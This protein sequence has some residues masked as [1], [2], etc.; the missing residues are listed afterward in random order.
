[1]ET[2]GPSFSWRAANGGEIVL[3]LVGQT[4]A[5]LPRLTRRYDP[6]L[7][8]RVGEA[9]NPGPGASRRNLRARAMQAA[10]AGGGQVDFVNALVQA[11]LPAL[12]AALNRGGQEQGAAEAGNKKEKDKKSDTKVVPNGTVKAAVTRIQTAEHAAAFC[13]AK[14]VAPRTKTAAPAAADASVP[15]ERDGQWQKVAG[16]IADGDWKLQACDWTA[17]VCDVDSL[18]DAV[19]ALPTTQTPLAR[20]VLLEDE[21][22]H[23]V[24]AALVAQLAQC[25]LTTVRRCK[26][27]KAKA[28][29]VA[30]GVQRI[31]CVHMAQMSNG[32]IPPPG[33]RTRGVSNPS[34]LTKPRS[35]ASVVL[36]ISPCKP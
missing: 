21:E 13:A 32:Q 19:R 12:I 18:S 16:K 26:D 35:T 31:M 10:R 24:A 8:V 6:F 7:G 15:N 30:K 14:P 34:T 23:V 20:I 1:M 11:L 28:P 5:Q 9:A 29:F 2:A 3:G 4:A 17:E 36:K 27:G 33:L 22:E 25:G